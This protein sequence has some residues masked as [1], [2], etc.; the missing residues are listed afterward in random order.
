MTLNA[1][2]YVLSFSGWAY[3]LAGKREKAF[4][5]INQLLDEKK[6]QFTPAFNVA[7]VY[8]G[9]NETDKTYEWLETAIEERN[10]ELVY[11]D[12]VSKAGGGSLW[13]KDFR[14]DSRFES[15]MRRINSPTNDSDKLTNETSEAQTAILSPAATDPQENSLNVAKTDEQTSQAD[16]PK[17]KRNWLLIALLSLV[18]LVGGFF[19]YRYFTPN[20]KQIESIAVLPFVNESGSADVEYLS[21]GMTETLIS[22]LSQLPN[23]NVK[24][25]SSVFRYKGKET[26]AQTIGKELNVQ[27]I[28]HGRVVQRGEQLTLYLEL[29]DALTG[30]RIWGD[31]YNRKQT[32]LI[33]L[34]SEI[35]RDV[36]QKLKT[37][38]SGADEQKLAKN[39]T[40]NAE[41]YKLYLQGRFYWN[42]RTTNDFRKAIEYF[43]QAITIDQNY[44]LAYAGLA[45][46][47]GLLSAFGGVPPQEA[48]PKAREAALKAL[49]LDDRLERRVS[50][51]SGQIKNFIL[52]PQ[53]DAA[54]SL[55]E[56]RRTSYSAVSPD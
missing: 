21:D 44:A 18:V 10:G 35:A 33:T 2:P 4:A 32:E 28:V 45:D 16:K 30:N 51:R 29:V 49:L 47:Y 31:Q 55:G 1:T 15:L 23:L 13:G 48:M 54:I 7:R 38:L 52:I 27:A 11:L 3:A 43:N 8:G 56:S 36:S 25:R 6:R 46:A 22:S 41:A 12:V 42:K 37:K 39:Y 50:K 26:D 34:Q 20:S 19:A 17:T 40:E 9:L 24:A 14:A 53:K 5:V